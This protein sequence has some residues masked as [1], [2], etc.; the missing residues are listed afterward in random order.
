MRKLS[1]S[2]LPQSAR[3]ASPTPGSAPKKPATKTR[4]T[5]RTVKKSAALTEN[6]RTTTT[7][8]PGVTKGTAT[9]A[10]KASETKG[11]DAGPPSNVR[12]IQTRYWLFKTEPHVFSIDDLERSPDQTAVWS[13][14]RNY[15][16]RNSLRD[17]VQL[18][19]RVLIYHSSTNPLAIVGIG[20]IVRAGYPDPAA[21]NAADP[22]FDPKGKLDSPTWYA[23]DIK[24][25]H[26]FPQPLLRSDLLAEPKLKEMLLL[27]RGSRLSI[28]P[29]RE[30]EWQQILNMVESA[31]D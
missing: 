29:V 18:G 3:A 14:V 7:S 2:K 26:R 17:D 6:V 15:Q 30:V 5:K 12:A 28:Q 25:A 27:Q 31:A 1:M 11:A 21:F 24:L 10:A 13:G 19:D 23:V 4:A 8:K 9:K 16:A 22:Y 20:E